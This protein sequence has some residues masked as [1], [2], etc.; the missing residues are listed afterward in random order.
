M[1]QSPIGNNQQIVI[2]EVGGNISSSNNSPFAIIDSSQTCDL[3]CKS[4]GYQSGSCQTFAITPDAF[5]LKEEYEKTHTPIGET[6]D[7]YNSG[8]LGITKG[9]Y[10]TP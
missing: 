3:K 7:C 10:C 9:C 5:A 8:L 4:Q 6:A 2:S 1:S